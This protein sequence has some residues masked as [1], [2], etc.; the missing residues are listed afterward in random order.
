[1]TPASVTHRFCLAHRHATP[2]AMVAPLLSRSFRHGNPSQLL[3]LSL[4]LLRHHRN[5]V[6][7]EPEPC[8]HG[9]LSRV[10]IFNGY[11]LDTYS[12]LLAPF[13]NLQL[14]SDGEIR[15]AFPTAGVGGAH[16][17]DGLDDL[18]VGEAVGALAGEHIDNVLGLLLGTFVEKG[19]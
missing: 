10:A 2:G 14:Q 13:R 9:L 15:H 4:V 5:F 8:V 17:G 1:M 18:G 11:V 3:I 19:R 16:D 7:I 12:P 6:R